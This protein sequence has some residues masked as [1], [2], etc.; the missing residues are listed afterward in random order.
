[1][2]NEDNLILVDY[3]D[4]NQAIGKFVFSDKPVNIYKAPGDPVHRVVEPGK[5][6]GSVKR[7]NSKGNWIELN[8]PYEQWVFVSDD[9]RFRESNPDNKPTVEDSIKLA[10]KTF[11]PI[12]G[13]VGSTVYDVGKGVVETAGNVL[14]VTAFIGRNL[15]WIVLIILIVFLLIIASKI[16]SFKL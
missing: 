14:D 8:T 7:F 12:T 13:K 1:M 10:A 5:Y 16:K 15:K 11:D 9:L 4:Q 3:V 2:D 6:I